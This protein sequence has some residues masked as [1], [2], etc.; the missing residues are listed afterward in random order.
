MTPE[1]WCTRRS[2]WTPSIRT[3]VTAV[4]SDQACPLGPCG[5]AAH[6][7]PWPSRRTIRCPLDHRPSTTSGAD[8]PWPAVPPRPPRLRKPPRPQ[9][10]SP[11]GCHSR[12]PDCRPAH[13]GGETSSMPHAFALAWPPPSWPRSW[14][15]PSNLLFSPSSLPRVTESEPGTSPA[16]RAFSI[17]NPM[18]ATASRSRFVAGRTGRAQ[19][20][21]NRCEVA[22]V[23]VVSVCGETAK[24]G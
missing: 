4:R 20:L 12:A 3:A 23:E 14:S 8:R 17:E 13:G 22:T 10:A 16:P 9:T 18:D 11:L 21:T 2:P 15:C 1:A 7:R 5:I 19:A 6:P 24:L